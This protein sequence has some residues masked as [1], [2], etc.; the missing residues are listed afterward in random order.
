LGYWS[1]KRYDCEAPVPTNGEYKVIVNIYTIQARDIYY[2]K[3]IRKIYI[4]QTVCTGNC[5][6]CSFNIDAIV[7]FI[8]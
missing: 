5:K 3:V 7:G 1:R 8:V 4:K 2:Y 6:N